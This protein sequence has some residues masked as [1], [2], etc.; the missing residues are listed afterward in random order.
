MNKIFTTLF[1]STLSYGAFAQC[2]TT[3][4]GGDLIISNDTT[5]SGEIVVGGTFRINSGV[6]VYVEQYAINNCGT[7]NIKASK[8]EII[9]DINANGAGYTGGTGGN[10]STTASSPTGDQNSLTG[11]SNKD[12]HGQVIVHGAAAGAIGN[13]PGGGLA[14]S[15]GTNGSGPKQRCGNT[16]DDFGMIAG[17]GGAGA[18]AGGSYGGNGLNGG[19]GG[20][21]SAS[22]TR[23]GVSHPTS[24]SVTKGLGGNGGSIN[25]IYGTANGQDI[26]LGSGGAGAGGGGKSYHNGT[27]GNT[28]GNGG[29]AIILEG[30]DSLIIIGNLFTNGINGG[31]GG[32][33][34]NGDKTQDCCGDGC[35]D[36]GERNFSAGAGGGG[37]AG[38]GSGGGILIKA[39]KFLNIAG[40]FNSNG[41]NGGNGGTGGTGTSGSYSAT[42]C[43]SQSVSTGAGNTGNAGGA[44]SGGRIKFFVSECD[45]NIFTP[46]Y[47]VAGGTSNA[48]NADS[49]TYHVEIV[50]CAIDN[51]NTSINDKAISLISNI[52][53]NPASD[54]IFVT[55]NAQYAYDKMNI[56]IIDQTGRIIEERMT[57][58]ETYLQLN[59]SGLSNGVYFVKVQN[60]N[61]GHTIKK[62]IKQ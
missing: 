44:G 37:G 2:P 23:S 41:G 18:G 61:F 42:L 47:S 11:C 36:L 10:G 19:N 20:D 58:G 53:P 54:N 7:L 25:T 6:T 35:N 24:Y 46:T 4:I 26:D 17:A 1:L 30:T 5:L 62:F 29:G 27:G 43:G 51:N 31:N 57:S 16:S 59:V 32:N 28:G 40:S 9:G 45:D 55:L 21:G 22:V 3:Q 52:F 38:A 49:G 12:D 33:G 50:P 34:G 48:T 14:G 56:S 13:G 39:N 8:I 60:A 15:N